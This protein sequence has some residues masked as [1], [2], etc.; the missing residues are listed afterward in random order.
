MSEEKK[1][2]S[3]KKKV[4]AVTLVLFVICIIAFLF[5]YK[6]QQTGKY[7]DAREHMTEGQKAFYDKINKEEVF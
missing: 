6:Y 4:Y 2:M 3:K 5:V 7:G 1:P